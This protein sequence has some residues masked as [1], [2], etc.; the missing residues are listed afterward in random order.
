MSIKKRGKDRKPRHIWTIEEKEYLTNIARLTWKFFK[1]NITEENN[2]L[3]CAI[4]SCWEK[5]GADEKQA[6]WQKCRH[7][8]QGQPSKTVPNA[9]I[10]RYIKADPWRTGTAYSLFSSSESC[11][12]SCWSTPLSPL[13]ASASPWTGQ[14]PWAG[15]GGSAC[16]HSRCC[17][18]R[19]CDGH[20]SSRP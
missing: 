18:A 11:A 4:L 16:L 5:A 1:D 2:Y 15:G 7:G 20:G 12:G 6:L 13:P 10:S 14:S 9:N 8:K 3:I 19:S 17:R